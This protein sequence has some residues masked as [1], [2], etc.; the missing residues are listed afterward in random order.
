MSLS[1]FQANQ[2]SSMM[3]CVTDVLSHRIWSNRTNRDAQ[4]TSQASNVDKLTHLKFVFMKI[5]GRRTSHRI[6]R[7]PDI[8]DRL[9]TSKDLQT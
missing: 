5:V 2:G 4:R 9:V 3:G 8:T 1:C 7:E 6:G